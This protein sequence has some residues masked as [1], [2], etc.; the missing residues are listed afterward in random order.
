[1]AGSKAELLEPIHPLCPL[2]DWFGSAAPRRDHVSI[3]Q[4]LSRPLSK[5][6]A[7]LCAEPSWVKP[8]L[9]SPK[10]AQHHQEG[11]AAAEV[12]AGVNCIGELCKPSSPGGPGILHEQQIFRGLP[13]TEVW[14]WGQGPPTQTLT[15]WER[16]PPSCQASP[17]GRKQCPY[18]GCKALPRQ[19]LTFSASVLGHTR[20]SLSRV[21]SAVAAQT[22]HHPS[23]SPAWS[24]APF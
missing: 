24:Q 10:G 9:S 7:H 21:T 13:R 23:S 4:H 1:M 15:G 3:L 5:P 11:E 22:G 12:G 2:C 19:A 14:G 17:Q 6:C 20:G 16:N 18:A 8:F